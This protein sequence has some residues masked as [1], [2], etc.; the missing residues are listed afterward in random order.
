M[1]NK[2]IGRAFHPARVSHPPQ[3][4]PHQRGFTGP[5]V[6]GKID[7]QPGFQRPGQLAAQ[8]LRRR[9]AGQET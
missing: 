7:R 1:F 9:L 6:A 3:D 2:R 4:S 5:Q 8:R